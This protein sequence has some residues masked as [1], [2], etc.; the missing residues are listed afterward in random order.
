MAMTAEKGMSQPSP[1]GTLRA[2]RAHGANPEKLYAALGI[3]MPADVVDFSTNTCALPWP[4]EAVARVIDNTARLASAYP[5][6]ECLALRR[7]IA[8]KQK[9]AMIDAIAELSDLPSELDAP[10]VRPAQNS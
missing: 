10:V 5:D 7:L 6:D 8:S 1:D 3:P 2:L 9:G 4:D